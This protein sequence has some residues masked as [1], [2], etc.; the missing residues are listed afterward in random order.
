MIFQF[1]RK[2]NRIKGGLLIID[3]QED[4]PFTITTAT[5]SPQ[6]IAIYFRNKIS[7][8][9]MPLG[10]LINHKI[11]VNIPAGEDIWIDGSESA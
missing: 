8:W 10:A 11:S 9:I 5:K 2:F 3:L 1:R 6:M 4:V 7:A